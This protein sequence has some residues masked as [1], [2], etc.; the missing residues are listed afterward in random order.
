M[1]HGHI[2][3]KCENSCDN[4]V[5]CSGGLALCTICGGAEGSLLTTCPGYKLSNETLDAC[6]R[7]NV[8]D[9]DRFRN[10]IKNGGRIQNGHIIWR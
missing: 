10:A 9:L 6:Y 7:G 3:H 8:K 2:L 4:C 1:N 5:I